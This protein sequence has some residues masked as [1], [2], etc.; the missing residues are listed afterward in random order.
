RSHITHTPLA[1][2]QSH[3][4]WVERHLFELRRGRDAIQTADRKLTHRRSEPSVER[5]QRGGD[6]GWMRGR[7][8]VVREDRMLAVLALLCMA[9][10]AA[11]QAAGVLEPPVPAARRLEQVAADGA[12]VAELR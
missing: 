2:S 8:E 7:A 1:C 4:D 12:H 3:L 10:V 9:A 6:I 11:V 5:K